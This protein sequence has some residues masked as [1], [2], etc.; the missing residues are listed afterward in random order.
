MSSH[1]RIKDNNVKLKNIAAQHSAKSKKK[2]MLYKG[3][4]TQYKK[5]IWNLSRPEIYF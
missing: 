5:Q 4:Y 2:R 3:F 1:K